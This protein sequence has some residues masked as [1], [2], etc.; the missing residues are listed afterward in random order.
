MRKAF[1]LVAILAVA[2]VGCQTYGGYGTAA[3]TAASTPSSPGVPPGLTEYGYPH[4]LASIN[5]EPGQKAQIMVPDQYSTGQVNG[6]MTIT[7]PGDAFSVPVRFEVLAGS[8]SSWDKQ[9]SSDL[10]VVANFAYRV[11]DRNTG[12]LVDKFDNPVTWEVQ[13]PMVNMNSVYWA[14]T[15]ANP[16]KLIDANAASKIMGDTLEHAQP[17]AL[18]G[19]IVTTPKSAIA[20]M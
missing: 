17:V 1:F 20:G 11:I 19:W 6:Y 16:P 10:V 13:D 3:S 5:L 4:V 7:I 18:V 9:V 2:L 12:K 14:T 15:A 8:N